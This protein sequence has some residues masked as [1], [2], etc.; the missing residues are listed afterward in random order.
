M[1]ASWIRSV[2]GGAARL[3]PLGE[4]EHDALADFPSERE[5]MPAGPPAAV[6]HRPS[7]VTMRVAPLSPGIAVGLVLVLLFGAG[8]AALIG[9]LA[10]DRAAVSM[11]NS[12][13]SVQP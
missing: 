3:P 10:T 1:S 6:A 9:V 7:G 5:A 4:A 13:A 8:S 11:R 2:D 12:F